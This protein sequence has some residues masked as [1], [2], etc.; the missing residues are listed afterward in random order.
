MIAYQ[1]KNTGGFS[2]K[3]APMHAHEKKLL[4]KAQDTAPNKSDNGGKPEKARTTT[5]K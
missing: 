3:R 2:A 4:S 5:N 1:V